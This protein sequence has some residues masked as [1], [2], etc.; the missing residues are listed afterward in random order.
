MTIELT[1]QWHM[2]CGN[3]KLFCA[4]IKHVDL[5]CMSFQYGKNLQFIKWM[6]YIKFYA[7]DLYKVEH[8]TFR[9]SKEAAMEDAEKMGLQLSLDIR[10]GARAIMAKY[11]EPDIK[12]EVV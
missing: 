4:A 5:H 7:Y 12:G 1:E 9:V 10:D 2:E 8:G 6:G 3:P 11:G